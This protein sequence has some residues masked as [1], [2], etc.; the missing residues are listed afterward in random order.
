[1]LKPERRGD[2][3]SPTTVW[4]TF[5]ENST[6]N[7]MEMNKPLSTKQARFFFLVSE[8]LCNTVRDADI[9]PGYRT[10]HSMLTLEV[11]FGEDC[12]KN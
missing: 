12:I 11:S 2:K 7:Y 8:N 4:W 9:T 6:R 10:D 1:M 5:G 3:L